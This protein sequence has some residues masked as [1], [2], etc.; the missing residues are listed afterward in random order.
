MAQA[1]CQSQALVV[2]CGVTAHHVHLNYMLPLN[3]VP[4]TQKGACCKLWRT[5]ESTVQYPGKPWCL[6]GKG[7]ACRC[8]SARDMGSIPGLGRSSGEGNG[9]PLQYSC[10]GNPMD[11]GAWWA[12]VH[13]VAKIWTQLSNKT[14]VSLSSSK[15]SGPLV[16]FSL[17][18][19][20]VSI[21]RPI[22]SKLEALGL[23]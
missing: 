16:D 4:L 18:R 12:T 3:L 5:L 6:S 8:T 23:E 9:N 19:R 13:G 21:P 1:E 15:K 14:T 20:S 7:S 22:T 2:A 17:D 10:L 11:R